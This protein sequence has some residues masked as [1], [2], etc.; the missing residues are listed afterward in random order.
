MCIRDSALNAP[1][2]L[3]ASWDFTEMDMV[4][5]ALQ[6]AVPI[7]SLGAAPSAFW[8]LGI[9][10]V[11]LLEQAAPATHEASGAVTGR[12]LYMDA[13]VAHALRALMDKADDMSHSAEPT[14]EEAT[15]VTHAGSM[16]FYQ[17]YTDLC[18]LYTSPSPRDR[19]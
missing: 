13:T 4:R 18:L 7:A 5:A 10:K 16:P 17:V 14:L 1:D 2:A 6:L 11:F 15:S 8:W 9:Y 19:G 12:D 3:P